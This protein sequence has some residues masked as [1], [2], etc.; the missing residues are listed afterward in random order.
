MERLHRNPR[1]TLNLVLSGGGIKGIAYVGV[2]EAAEKRGYRW[3]NIAGVSAGALAGSFVSA[4]YSV[5]E[6]RAIM[7]AFD[8][9]GLE[10]EEVSKKV[11]S[12]YRFPQP[13]SDTRNYGTM[14]VYQ[15]LEQLPGDETRAT[16][17]SNDTFTSYRSGMIKKAVTFSQE[18]HV[19]DGDGLEEWVWKTLERRGI[20]TFGD[21]R[22]GMADKVNPRGYKVRMTAVDATKGR[23]IV[24]PDDMADYGMDPDRMEVAKAVRMSTSVP[25]AFKP[26]EIKVKKEEMT[27]VH[28]IVDGGVFDNFPFWL[29][30]NS[31]VYRKVG[32]RLDGGEKKL[33]SWDAPLNLFK[34]LV[35]AVHDIGIPKKSYNSGLVANIDTSKV[36][37]LDFNL[38]EEEKEYLMKAGNR[39]ASFLLG[40][41]KNMEMYRR[42][43]GLTFRLPR[44]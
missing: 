16:G 15:F 30:E 23:V 35:A 41:I 43:R 33:L 11:S 29:I 34:S 31:N 21:L 2:F 36:S 3:G 38:G 24:L 42:R 8:F 9:G 18:G 12:M 7:D 44:L 37:F 39:S 4:G 13:G 10:L 5:Q 32:F 20:R 25:F 19:F 40:K 27:R 6:I 22:G 1:N 14:N 26:V 17:P 28:Y